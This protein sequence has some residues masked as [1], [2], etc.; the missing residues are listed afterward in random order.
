MRRSRA[1]EAHLVDSIDLMRA[2]LKSGEN[3]RQALIT[4]ARSSRNDVGVALTQAIQQLELGLSI[5]QAFRRIRV[6]YPSPS[7]ALFVNV[8][9]AKWE[10]GADLSLLLDSINRILRDQLRLASKIRSELSGTRYALIFI[11]L[12]PYSIIGMF[13]WLQ[14][15]WLDALINHEWG[16]RFFISAIALQFIGYFWMRRILRSDYS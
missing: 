16:A 9:I 4:A 12:M 1:F 8:L 5:E 2:A 15:D 10:G 13:L 14:P 3:P 6:L 7:V 11:G